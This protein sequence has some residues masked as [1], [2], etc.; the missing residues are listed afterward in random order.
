[1]LEPQTRL[2]P[3]SGGISSANAFPDTDQIRV[4]GTVI[5]AGVSQ[6]F[7]G[8]SKNELDDDGDLRQVKI[9][10]GTLLKSDNVSF[11]LG[12]GCS[13]EAGGVSLAQVP[14]EVERTLLRDGMAE[15]APKPW[16]LLFYEIAAALTGRAFDPFVRVQEF[17]EE[18]EHG[19]RDPPEAI[20]VNFELLLSKL[21]ALRAGL[22]AGLANLGDP[23]AVPLNLEVVEELLAHLTGVLARTCRLP[24]KG[25]EEALEV[26]RTLIK[27][28]LTRPVNLRRVNLFTLNYDTLIEQAAD[29]E[30]VVL[31]DGFTGL[32]RRTF[33]PESYDR[34]L[35]FPAQTTEGRVHRVDRV[36]HLYKLHGSIT[37]RRAEPTWE[38][39]YG[40]L[41]CSDDEVDRGDNV[42]IYPTPSKHGETLAFPYSELFRRFASAIV[43]P[44]AV[45]F[46]A[47]Y[48]FGD[49]H[50]NAVIRQAL[51]IPS[52]TLVVI[53]PRPT[54]T[55]AQALADAE[56]QRVWFISGPNLGTF[57]GFVYSLLPDL[58]EERISEKVAETY[59]S[60]AL[61]R[62]WE[63][64]DKRL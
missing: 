64:N 61:T 43:Q 16:L 6:N 42:I 1:M 31:I 12:A 59:R 25:R 13:L 30:G 32:L 33:R 9:R 29:S 2:L 49:D 26:H 58:Q 50:V 51:A 21:C 22:L 57:R 62:G 8:G 10:I 36:L 44:Q 20:T 5:W 38:N 54:S 48:G 3:G 7:T 56:D 55:F 15:G 45:L 47:G 39:P 23:S 46:V 60:L 53:N 63:P 24:K 34:D 41:A 4:G 18:A 19:H 37:W 17:Q 40:I 27:K 28:V 35:Y 14:L 52:F 11:L